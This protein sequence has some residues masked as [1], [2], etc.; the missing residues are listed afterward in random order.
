MSPRRRFS[1]I[2]ISSMTLYGKR[3][4]VFNFLTFVSKSKINPTEK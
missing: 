2:E 3:K 4:L 1:I